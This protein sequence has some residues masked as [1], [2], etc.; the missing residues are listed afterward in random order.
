MSIKDLRDDVAEEVEAILAAEFKIDVVKTD[1]VPH[2]ADPAITFPNL[3]EKRQGTKL[4]DTCVLY[5]DIRRSTQLNLVHRQHTVAKLYSAFVRAMTRCARYHKGHVRGIIGDRVMVIFDRENAFANAM[6]CAV[7]MNSTSQY[8]I[9][10]YFKPG[11]V[12]CGIGIDAG[13][14]L[15]T[16]TGVRRRGNEQS[17]YRSLVWLGRPA[18]VA[19]KLTDLANKPEESVTIP[20]VQAAFQPPWLPSYNWT[21]TNVY[22]SDFIRSLSID[23]LSNRIVHADPTF[24]HMLLSQEKY[25]TKPQTPPILITKAVMDGY[26][27]AA[28]NSPIITQRMFSE[29][30]LQVP[31]YSGPVFGGDVIFTDFDT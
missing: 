30:K 8:I 12:E 19:S 5:I 1:T 26:R 20:I 13:R 22:P 27:A 25:V 9:N 4:I 29:I 14:M 7:A 3:D 24:Q 21:W 17:A 31:G 11:E 15:A 28:P 23:G 10:R 18:N 2:S 16:K 6:G